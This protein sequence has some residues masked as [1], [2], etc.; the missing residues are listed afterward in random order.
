MTGRVIEYHAYNLEKSISYR[1]QFDWPQTDLTTAGLAYSGNHFFEIFVDEPLRT[2][3]RGEGSSVQI[4]EKEAWATYQKYLSCP[5]ASWDRKERND[6]WAW[7]AECGMFSS[8]R[9]EVIPH[10]LQSTLRPGEG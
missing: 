4:A 8:E 3:I 7:C 1:C 9:V 10:V 5:H 2:Y 6:G